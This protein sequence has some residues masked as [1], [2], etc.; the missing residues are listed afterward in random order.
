MLDLSAVKLEIRRKI[1]D[2]REQGIPDFIRRDGS[3]F[4]AERMVSVVVGSRRSGKSFRCFQEMTDLI[5]SGWL[6][7]LQQV[8]SIDFDNP[9]FSQMLS[10]D[11][12]VIRDTFLGMSPELNH[13]TN[14]LFVFDEI[15]RIAGWEDFVVELSRNPA[16]RVIVTGSSSRMLKTDVSTTLRGKSISSVVYP[17]SFKEL[18]RF[19]NVDNTESTEGRARTQTLFE[20]YLKW[21]G[22][23]QLVRLDS[24]V[25]EVLL[26]EYFD[27]MI[28]KDI[29]QR[30]NVSRPQQCMA[31]YRYLLSLC[32]KPFTQNSALKH[33]RHTGVAA[34]GAQLSDYVEWAEDSWFLFGVP[35][36]SDS[37]TEIVRNYRKCYAIDWALST[38]N[39]QSW[40]GGYSRAFE[41]LVYL[42][43]KRSYPRVNYYLTKTHRQEVDFICVDSTGKAVLAVQVCLRL[44]DEDVIRREL[45]PLAAV[46]KYIGIKDV[47][48]VTM[49][50]EMVRVVDGVTINVLPA[51]RWMA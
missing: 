43:L 33:L 29:I 15:H 8:C 30:Y 2:L 38:Q 28:F 11:L 47:M 1:N 31:F 12:G 19:H 48:V 16:W 5:S 7:S 51:W 9:H 49:Y 41:N 14:L 18:L 26:R 20:D 10:T 22:F 25:K 23:P 21:G 50:D 40:D 13:S 45:P 39:S 37:Q 32:G 44:D 35:L 46:S 6:K 27:T 3:L 42:Q 36:F 17:L 24:S 34:T 4:S